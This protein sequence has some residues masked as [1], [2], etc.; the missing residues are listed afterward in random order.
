MSDVS[1]DFRV[2]GEKRIWIYNYFQI[3]AH[4][5]VT[6]RHEELILQDCRH[7]NLEQII[8]RVCFPFKKWKS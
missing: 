1:H 4:F 3:Y 7:R 5:F 8:F 2:F 6:F